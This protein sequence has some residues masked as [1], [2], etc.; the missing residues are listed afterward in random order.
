[1]GGS[2][3]QSSSY[4]P[5]GQFGGFPAGP[6]PGMGRF[7]GYGGGLGGVGGYQPAFPQTGSGKGFQSMPPPRPQAQYAPMQFLPP[8][9]AQPRFM[10]PTVAGQMAG[11][12]PVALPQPV[13]QQPSPTYP[14]PPVSGGG[15]GFQ[16]GFRQPM[17]PGPRPLPIAPPS[18]G[19]GPQPF[20][21]GGQQ[22]QFAL[23]GPGQG[24]GPEPMPREEME[25]RET[26]QP[27]YADSPVSNPKMPDYIPSRGNDL[28]DQFLMDQYEV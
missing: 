7:G 17:P 12:R 18:P 1:M 8:Q 13:Y 5:A 21:P 23:L 11:Q 10:Y 27:I 4:M 20:M 6:S 28:S 22:D 2:T 25:P 16:G 24:S 9:F 3:T 14:F 26:I 15:K 19:G